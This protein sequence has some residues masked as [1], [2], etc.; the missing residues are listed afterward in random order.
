MD[1]K[2]QL[3]QSLNLL[4][5]TVHE[6]CIRIG[7]L[8]KK[9]IV[10]EEKNIALE[11]TIEKL[12]KDSNHN[13][14]ITV[15]PSSHKSSSY[16]SHTV[17]DGN[18]Y[19]SYSRGPKK[20]TG[21]LDVRVDIHKSSYGNSPSSTQKPYLTINGKT[22]ELPNPSSA[23]RFFTERENND[24]RR[25]A[26]LRKLCFGPNWA[27]KWWHELYWYVPKKNLFIINTTFTLFLLLNNIIKVWREEAWFYFVYLTHQF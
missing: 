9:N 15:S 19:H 17:E 21:R 5:H 6:N 10:L 3:E 2:S 12:V 26:S 20:R 7:E 8:E 11:K 25:Y 14:V 24:A 13:P 4:I 22:S 23:K 16:V 18:N 27:R 1:L